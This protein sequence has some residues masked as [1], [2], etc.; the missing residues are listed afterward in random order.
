MIIF[1]TYFMTMNL[2][3]TDGE[4]MGSVAAQMEALQNR[5][6]HLDVCSGGRELINIRGSGGALNRY[7]WFLIYEVTEYVGEPDHI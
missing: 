7:G 2:I 1:K 3:Y 6:H 5:H 4:K